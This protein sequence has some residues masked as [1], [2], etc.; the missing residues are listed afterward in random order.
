MT[1][2]SKTRDF[3]NSNPLA[4]FSMGVTS[5]ALMAVGVASGY[6]IAPILINGGT[7]SL[8]LGMLGGV[9]PILAFAAAGVTASLAATCGYL[10]YRAGRAQQAF[11]ENNKQFTQNHGRSYVA[12]QA[13]AMALYA[14]VITATPSIDTI[15]N[16]VVSG[17]DE[18]APTTTLDQNTLVYEMTSKDC[19]G[20]TAQDFL[21]FMREQNV[22][23][24]CFQQQ[25]QP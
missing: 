16:A 8:M 9:T 1:L 4:S 3:L 15:F 13:A 5:G 6:A 24:Y 23:A 2:I 18:S 7:I 19:A 22:P 10:T 20:E 14:A 21:R 12:G 17:P 11:S 25:P